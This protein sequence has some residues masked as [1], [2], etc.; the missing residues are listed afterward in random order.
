[1]AYVYIVVDAD[2]VPLSFGT[3]WGASECL[4]DNIPDSITAFLTKGE[5]DRALSLT[6]KYAKKEN[7]KTLWGMEDWK[8]VGVEVKSPYLDLDEDFEEE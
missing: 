4:Y 3:P 5:A 1:M 6:N 7:L 2:D 8:I